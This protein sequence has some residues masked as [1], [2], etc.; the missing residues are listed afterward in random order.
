MKKF[1]FTTWLI[2][3][4]VLTASCQFPGSKIK[5]G[6]KIGEMEFLNVW[7]DCQAPNILNDLCTQIQL[8]EGTCEVALSQFWISTGWMEGSQ[9]AMEMEWEDSEWSMTFDGREVDLWAFGTFDM[10]WTDPIGV[11]KDVQYA[12]VWNV[13]ISNPPL[14]AHAVEYEFILKHGPWRGVHVVTFNFTVL[15]PETP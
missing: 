2:L 1:A 14:G 4:A 10:Q 12:R 7:E 5:P 3:F 6:D 9:E 15:A 8:D 11:V 13:C